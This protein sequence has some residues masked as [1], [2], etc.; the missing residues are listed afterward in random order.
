M[1]LHDLYQQYK[2]TI[3]HK[4]YQSVILTI[5]HYGLVP[6]YK[7]SHT[8]CYSATRFVFHLFYLPFQFTYKYKKKYSKYCHT[9]QLF[10]EMFL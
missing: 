6:V 7:M 9:Y 1:I 5:K 8:F 2:Y 4:Q 3:E 10:L